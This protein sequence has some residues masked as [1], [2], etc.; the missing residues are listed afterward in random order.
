MELLPEPLKS[1]IA[2]LSCCEQMLTGGKE[3][4]SHQIL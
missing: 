1:A 2:W 4:D 3:H